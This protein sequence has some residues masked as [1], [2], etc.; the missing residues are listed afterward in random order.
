MSP[1]I[2]L[3]E[4]GEIDAS[5]VM[6]QDELFAVVRDKYPVTQGHSLIVPKRGVQR[7]QE[8]TKTE[9]SRLLH[10]LAWTQEYL[11]NQEVPP[12]DS[13]NLGVNDGPAA[14]GSGRWPHE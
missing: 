7:F 1:L 13:F 10:W 4:F 3:P 2:Q 5:R 12:P 14:I 11:T 6:A 9:Q 8:L